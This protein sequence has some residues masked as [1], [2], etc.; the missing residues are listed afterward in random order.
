MVALTFGVSCKVSD[1]TE[2]ALFEKE[3]LR[4]FEK[5]SFLADPPIKAE[6]M[7]H[8]GDVMKN[9]TKVMSTSNRK[10]LEYGMLT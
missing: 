6:A 7:M 4:G 3:A 9:D 10:F 1:N 2:G 5:G 8:G